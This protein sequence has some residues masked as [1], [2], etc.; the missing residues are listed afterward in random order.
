MVFNVE[1]LHTVEREIRSLAEK[2]L[3]VSK[4][5]STADLNQ[6]ALMKLNKNVLAEH[7][8]GFVQLFERN[9]ELCKSAASEVDQLKSDQIKTQSEIIELQKAEV[10]SVK[11]T[12]TTEMNSWADVVKKSCSQ[13]KIATVKAMENA[14]RSVTAEDE[15]AKNFIIHG[16]KEAADGK[17]EYL[18]TE[19]THLFEAVGLEEHHPD[20]TD[21]YR[22]GEKTAGKTRSIKVRLGNAETVRLLLSRAHRLRKF[23]MYK[24]V[25]LSPDRTKKDQAAHSSLV[26]EIKELITK[27]PKKYHFIRD[28]KI[29]SVDKASTG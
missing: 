27:E 5:S 18:T 15:R 8:E 14:V 10:G 28:G 9:L 12:L 11:E 3:K 24:N 23:N 26:R 2:V 25:Y 22:L 13:T 4:L 20:P 17:T 16:F 6:T 1:Q 21:A 19:A 7:L 29:R